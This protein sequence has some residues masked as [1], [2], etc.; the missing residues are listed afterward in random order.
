MTDDLESRVG[1]LEDE[2][3]TLRKEV[4]AVRETANKALSRSIDIKTDF[5]DIQHSDD[6]L[7]SEVHELRST[8]RNLQNEIA[9]QSSDIETWTARLLENML[10]E[11]AR[12]GG[13]SVVK[14]EEAWSRLDYEP[15]RTTL[16]DVFDTADKKAESEAVNYES[17]SR[18]YRLQLDVSKGPIPR[19]VGLHVID[20]PERFREDDAVTVRDADVEA[21]HKPE[22]SDAV[23]GAS[24]TNEYGETGASSAENDRPITTTIGTD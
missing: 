19:T 9:N 5:E 12:S 4:G 13:R 17:D 14:A 1:A 21:L 11:A 16:Y 18:P 2:L 15:D 6:R 8:V 20:V 22:R 23:C 10:Q 3:S 24:T 7:R